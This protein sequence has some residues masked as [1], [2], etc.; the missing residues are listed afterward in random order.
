MYPN[1]WLELT[2]IILYVTQNFRIVHFTYKILLYLY[3]SLLL[4]HLIMK[5][6][7]NVMSK[8][9]S[10]KKLP[11]KIN[12]LRYLNYFYPER[13]NF[14]YSKK[15]FQHS[16]RCRVC[17]ALRWVTVR[18]NDSSSRKGALSLVLWV[19]RKSH[20]RK[21]SQQKNRV[22]CEKNQFLTTHYRLSKSRFYHNF[23]I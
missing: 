13:T 16:H 3:L 7:S 12:I 4:L 14:Y 8:G 20:I 18:F 11:G 22:V 21:N 10:Q 19:Y 23:T 1:L 17:W 6:I 5:G 9:C 2:I 15:A